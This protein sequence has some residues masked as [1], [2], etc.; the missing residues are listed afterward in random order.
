[1]NIRFLGAHNSESKDV[2][3]AC[4]LI[5]NVLAID[6]GGLTSSLTFSEQLAIK[7]L[8]VTHHHYDHIKDIPM[9]G[10]TFYINHPKSTS[11][12]SHRSMMPSNTFSNTRGSFILIF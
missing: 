1:M 3:P 2:R 8:L 10:M 4:L 5:D 11:I 9:M 7:A 6:A 12:L